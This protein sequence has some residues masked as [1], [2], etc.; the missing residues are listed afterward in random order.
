MQPEDPSSFNQLE[1]EE[2]SLLSKSSGSCPGDTSYE[3]D[4]AK[5]ATNHDS[6]DVDIRGLA[7]LSH[8]KFYLLW[9][10]LGILASIGLMTINNLGSDVSF[11]I[12]YSTFDPSHPIHRPVRYGIIT[13]T[14]PPQNSYKNDN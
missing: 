1:T 12:F 11:P 3:E 2:S 7:L 4:K 10:E 5:N 8:M 14:V 9:L 6:H 13:T